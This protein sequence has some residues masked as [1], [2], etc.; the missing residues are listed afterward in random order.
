MDPMEMLLW[1]LALQSIPPAVLGPLMDDWEALMARVRSEISRQKE[2]T[3][4]ALGR[5]APGQVKVSLGHAVPGHASARLR[6]LLWVI[7][8]AAAVLVL[9][10][11]WVAT[12]AAGGT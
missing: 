2:G 5:R 3:P 1:K 7:L 9:A 10:L 6:A 4:G 11:L 8:A 12:K